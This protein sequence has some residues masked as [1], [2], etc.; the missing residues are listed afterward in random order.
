MATDRASGGELDGVVDFLHE[1]GHLKRVRRNGWSLASVSPDDTVAAHSFRVAMIAFVLAEMAEMERAAEVV[2]AALV[3]DIEETRLG[4]LDHVAQRYVDKPAATERIRR[5]Q[6]ADL[7]AAVRNGLNDAHALG[8]DAEF[9]PVL[10]DA[11]ALEG[12][13]QAW[14]LRHTGPGLMTEWAHDYMGRLELPESKALA[15]AVLAAEPNRWWLRL[16]G[17]R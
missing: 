3:H 16:L 17:H 15:A 1:C 12:L 4:D 8:Q 6:L 9:G 10:R 11:D 7:P 14:E 5:E 2:V 13:L